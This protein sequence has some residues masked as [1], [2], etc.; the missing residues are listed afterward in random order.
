MTKRFTAFLLLTALNLTGFTADIQAQE[1]YN[2]S[3]V[4]SLS[5]EQAISLALQANRSLINS[6]SG[7]ESQKLSLRSAE[8]EFDVKIRPSAN[9]GISDA[10]GILGAGISLEKKFQAGTKVS[11]SPSI[12][13][14]EDEYSGTVGISFEVPLLRGF[15]GKAN[16]DKTERSRFSVRSAE[17]SFYLSQVNA[18][19]DTVSAVYDIVKQKELV[20]LF[21]SQVGRLKQHAETAK[22]KEKVGLANP[23]DI[24]RAEI[25]LKDAEDSLTV[26]KESLRNAGDRLKLILALPLERAVEVSAPL[27]I[28]IAPISQE[29]A[30]RI[31]LKHRKELE[32]SEDEIREAERRSD[33]ARHNILPQLDMVMRYER[34][35]SAEDLEQSMGF[36]ENRWSVNLV[37]N[38]D[39]ART[40]E[41]ADFQQSLITAGTARRNLEAKQDEVMREVR[42]ESESLSKSQERI[43]IRKEQIA[44]AEGKLALSKIK[45][46]H[47]MADNFDIIEAETQ[48]QQARVNLL[49]AE[50]EYIVGMYRMRAALGTLIIEN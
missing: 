3:S 33:I 2:D 29:D 24:Y 27:E 40:S 49:S 23:L 7:V 50:T 22:I 9:A 19:L 37:S 31:A 14:T 30:V 43:R 18:V 28:K 39:I 17:R 47:G 35:G 16:L 38:T 26:M 21:D 25:S 1:K 10:E 48:L 46:N 20:R 5:L 11:V 13:K 8:S 41:K 12:G 6:A 15:G 36:N 34:Y 42:R 44:Q 45:F 32:Q 4:I